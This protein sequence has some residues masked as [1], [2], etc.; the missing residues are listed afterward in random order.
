MAPSPKRSI[1]HLSPSAIRYA[2]VPARANSSAREGEIHFMSAAASEDSR[3]FAS[4]PSALSFG[5]EPV[6][7]P[8]L[9]AGAARQNV[10]GET[11][12]S[13]FA[14]PRL[15]AQAQPD[16]QLH[17]PDEILLREC[18]RPSLRTLRWESTYQ[19]CHA[20]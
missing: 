11:R 3:M 9:S 13:Y 7:S 8:S 1:R 6:V 17:R 16:D 2:S 4:R 10:R 20:Q 14:P 15:W 18:E 5:N 12:G 19:Q